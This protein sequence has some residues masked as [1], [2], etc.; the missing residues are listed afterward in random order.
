MI[1]LCAPALERR[2]K[3]KLELPIK[4]IHRTVGTTLSHELAKRHGPELLPDDTI[5]IKFNGSAGQSLGAWLAKGVTLE[6]EGDANDYFGK[7]L[8]GGKLMIYP[9]KNCSFVPEENIIIGNVAFYGAIAGEATS[10]AWRR[11]GSAY[12]T[13]AF[14]R[15]SKVWVT[16]AANT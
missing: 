1:R 2:E 14:A 5:Q 11:S 16:M 9:P 15:S 4:N 7:G 8:S 3:V 6:I 13:A 10:E 12:A